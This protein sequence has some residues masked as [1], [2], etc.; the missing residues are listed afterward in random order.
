[1]AIGDELLTGQCIE[2][3][4]AY[5]AERLGELGITVLAHWTIGDDPG[6]IADALGRAAQAAE[7]VFV[8]GGLGP[9]PDDLT[10]QALAQ[11]MGC[12]LA[13]DEASLA[14][15]EAF[16]RHRGRRVTET[17]RMQAMRPADAEAIANTMGTAPGISARLA[18][19]TVYCMPGVPHEMKAMFQQGIEPRLPRGDAVALRRVVHTFGMGESDIG[20]TLADLMRNEGDVRVGTTA[21][22][23]VISVRIVVRGAGRESAQATLDELQATVTERL[24]RIIFGQDDETL[25][26]AVGQ[27]LTKRGQTLA[28]A[29]SCT[30]GL[31]GQLITAVGGSSTYYL[32]GVVAYANQAK[33]DILGVPAELLEK[34]GAVSE[35]VAM[36]M[37]SGCRQRLGSDWAVAVTGVAGPT[38]GTTA[39]PVG[40]VFKAVA[41]PDGASAGGYQ[42][43]GDREIVRLRA[44]HSVLND[45]RLALL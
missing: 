32:G 2:T 40:L 5:L 45:L 26:S 15:I 27:L 23:G 34:H 1:M 39:K 12:P 30:G 33:C 41:G 9:T 24:G 14:H 18:K 44:A 20:T 11:A 25:A 3:N 16:F 35:R 4:S 13:L 42:F 6:D 19:A 21:K 17:N 31:V 38:G 8:S 36:A 37:A 28:T 7:L 29:E 43:P 22:A 10:R